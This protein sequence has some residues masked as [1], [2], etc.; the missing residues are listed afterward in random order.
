MQRFPYKLRDWNLE[1]EATVYGPDPDV[2]IPY[3]WIEEATFYFAHSDIELPR[4]A[5]DSITENEWANMEVAYLNWLAEQE[6]EY[7][8]SID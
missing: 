8:P 4:D 7:E 2:G 5:V 1:I 6:K 3:P